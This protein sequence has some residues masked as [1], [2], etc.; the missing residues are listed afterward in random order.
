MFDLII[1][2]ATGDYLIQNGD[3]VI[4]NSDS[5]NVFDILYS[6]KGEYKAHPKMGCGIFSQLNGP[7]DLQTIQ[8]IIST[9]LALDG[10]KVSGFGTSVVNGVTV[11]EPYA[12]R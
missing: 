5:Q 1:D 12:T 3:F 11:T 7:S 9:N 2:P 10:F 4:G 6:N 8:S